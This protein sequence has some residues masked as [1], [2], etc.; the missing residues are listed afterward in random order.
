MFNSLT[1][2]IISSHD[3]T[4]DLHWKNP[5]KVEWVKTNG[6][7]TL[8]GLFL[9]VIVYVPFFHTIN[10]VLFSRYAVQ[11]MIRMGPTV[12]GVFLDES[13]IRLSERGDF[14]SCPIVYG[15]NKDEGTIFLL[16]D[17]P[18]V[19]DSEDPPYVNKTLFDR[20][21]TIR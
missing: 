10:N 14:K 7:N 9:L 19:Y 13:P 2:V 3:A 20:V 1:E 8:H 5:M 12:D 16:N 17:L 18:N 6:E 21:R 4:L 15:F 11:N